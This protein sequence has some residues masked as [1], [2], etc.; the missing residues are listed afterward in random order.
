MQ[1][2]TF[3]EPTGKNEIGL[4]YGNTIVSM[5]AA[6][7]K[8]LAEK[9]GMPAGKAK[10]EAVE[11]I[12]DSMLDLIRRED[13]GVAS[14]EAVAEYLNQNR[15][16]WSSAGSSAGGERIAYSRKEVHI[17][18]P[19][20]VFR[21][22][23]VGANYNSYLSMMKIVPP[24]EGTTETFWKLPQAVIGPEEA[25]LWPASSNQISCEMEL[26]VI[27]GKKGK[28]ISRGDAFDYIFGYTIVNDVTAIDLV[29]R[30]LGE[31]REGLPGFYYLAL[32]K[33]MDTFE[34]I[35]PVITLKDEIKDPQNLS[36]EFR[37]NG[38]GR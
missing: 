19:L 11:Q 14:I 38:E 17:V 35:G 32:A 33:S 10:E 5:R 21:A 25:I 20:E 31:G 27:I 15:K 24:L 28:R 4:I 30:G 6:L 36:G 1:L 34:A 13:G 37:I 2:V 3:Q 7:A 8:V 12:P 26:G 29:K 23:N 9:R 18:K 22:L 16:V